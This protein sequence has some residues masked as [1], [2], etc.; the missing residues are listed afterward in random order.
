MKN[1]IKDNPVLA[2]LIDS[3]RREKK[4][5]WKRVVE[6]L[7]RSRRQRAEVN[8]S[9]LEAYADEGATVLVPGKVLGTG[10][11]SKKLNV[12]ALS[13]SSSAKKLISGSGGKTMSI[14]GLCK[15]NPEGKGVV[16]L[17]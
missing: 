5:I 8:L 10:T 7:S 14:D 2:S 9:K 4:P 13:F 3:L 15:S 16:L 6:E 17:K 12:A 1:K 11:L